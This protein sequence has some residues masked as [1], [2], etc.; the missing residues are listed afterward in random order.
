M[1][2]R[3]GQDPERVPSPVHAQHAPAEQRRRHVQRRRPSGRRGADR[4]ELGSADRGPRSGWMEG[5]LR[6]ERPREGSDVAG[7]RRLPGGPGDDGSGSQQPARGLPAPRRGDDLD[8]AAELRLPESRRSH[9]RQREP[10]VGPRRAELLQRRGLWRSGWRWCARSGREQREPGGLRLPEQR[11]RAAA[12]ASLSP[13]AAR[14]RGRQPVRRRRARHAARRGTAPRAGAGA[15][16]WLPVQ[17]GPRADLRARRL[18]HGGL[19]H[20][21]VAGRARECPGAGGG[22]PAPDREAGRGVAGALAR[23]RERG[24]R[25]ADPRGRHGPGRAAVRARGERLRGLR[26]RAPHPEAALD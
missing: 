14:G 25:R 23:A 20:G 6:D 12:E 13:G 26:S 22:R 16:A 5:H 18:R 21:R 3:S 8:Q 15:L 9:V 10:G 24:Q 2:H 19:G 4:L 1:G 17:C 11:P 7:L